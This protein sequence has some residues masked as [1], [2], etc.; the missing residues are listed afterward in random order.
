MCT[1]IAERKLTVTPTNASLSTSAG[2]MA[3]WK[4][5][6]DESPPFSIV[7][8][9]LTLASWVERSIF[10]ETSLITNLELISS[11]PRV[12]DARSKAAMA[13]K[14]KETRFI[15]RWKRIVRDDYVESP[16]WIQRKRRPIE[17]T[18]HSL[19]TADYLRNVCTSLSQDDSQDRFWHRQ[20]TGS[21]SVVCVPHQ[22]T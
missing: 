20:S 10:R 5:P 6:V 1:M 3:R 2:S 22:I 15:L 7:R 16:Q 19:C 21:P 9:V 8:E 13:A 18:V 11:F 12:K 14:R 17:P 4:Y